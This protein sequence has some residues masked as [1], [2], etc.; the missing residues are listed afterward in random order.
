MLL[1]VAAA[2][3]DFYRQKT[4][5]ELLI[6]VENPGQHAP[7]LV[8]GAVQELRRRGVAVPLPP[9]APA[10]ITDAAA[11]PRAW[12]R[13]AALALGL[14]ALGGGTYW[15][16]QR[17]DAEQ[18]AARAQAEAR[19]HLPPPRLTDE[20]THAIPNY[21]GAVARAVAQQLRQV[22]AAEQANAQHLRQFRELTRRFW[23]GETQT[24][25]LTGLAVAGQAGPE[26]NNQV[27]L[28]RETWHAW[29]RANAY[30]YSFG[31]AMQAQ[32]GRMKNA[33]SGQQHI[34]SD[35]PA[36]LPGRLF[37][38]NKDMVQRTAEVQDL[39]GGLLP[40]SPVSGRP[41]QRIVLDANAAGR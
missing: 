25:Y 31:P 29:N 11:P 1:P 2:A 22:P 3:S 12:G 37:L 36:L 5:D 27:R 33:A 21:D 26:F 6:F 40:V 30:G 28:V 18:A 17:S 7:D 14:L 39:V 16:K 13:A 35:L 38:T 10:S 20:P 8:A 19:R 4:D 41:Y 15:L 24:E 34:L 32:L 9:L 23:D